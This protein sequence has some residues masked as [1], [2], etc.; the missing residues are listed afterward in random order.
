MG[1]AAKCPVI[2]AMG[3]N[4]GPWEQT[5][6]LWRM[7]N[8][9]AMERSVERS[10]FWTAAVQ[11]PNAL[12][13][14]LTGICITRLLGGDGRGWYALLQSDVAVLSLLFSLNLGSGLVYFLSRAPEKADRI[15]GVAAGCLLF[16]SGSILLLMAA[17]WLFDLPMGPFLPEGEFRTWSL[18]YVG[19]MVVLAMSHSMFNGVFLGLRKFRVVNQM[20]LV[21][22]VLLFLAYGL[23]FVLR[24][25]LPERDTLSL[26][27]AVS[28]GASALVN[29]LWAVLYRVHVRSRPL[30]AGS[31]AMLR[32]ML[33]FS[34]VG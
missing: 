2:V 17:V 6:H 16:A 13:G 25:Q 33:A 26:V 9:T 5:R 30:L 27:L 8:G 18:V 7:P 14:F 34:L 3:N 1:M 12:M 28:L 20:T 19:L 4:G 29:V 21:S 22:S 11:L 23:F 32:P 10:I 24:H 31:Q 15:L